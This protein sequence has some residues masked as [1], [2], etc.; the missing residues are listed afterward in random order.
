VFELLRPRAELYEAWGEA[1]REWGPGLHEDG[2]GICPGDD[3]DTEHGFRAWIDRLQQEPGDLWW[4]V[5]NGQVLGGIALRSASD[6]TVGRLG[7]VGY[8]IRPSARGRGVATWA[9]SQILAHAAT[10]GIAPVLAACEEGNA[11]SI[12]TIEHF[13]GALL[14]TEIHG[15]VRVRY[16]AIPARP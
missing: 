10:L 7:H 14:R 4:V 5:E 9:L 1:H 11:G 12:A 2:F 13:G 15:S 3:V 16:Y 8:G 6:K